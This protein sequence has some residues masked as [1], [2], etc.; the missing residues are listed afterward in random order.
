MSNIKMRD[1]TIGF[2]AGAMLTLGGVKLCGK[3]LKGKSGKNERLPS[4][5][6]VVRIFLH[7][8]SSSL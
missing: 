7:S 4:M 3:F 2:L 5:G 6:F 1:A 8:G